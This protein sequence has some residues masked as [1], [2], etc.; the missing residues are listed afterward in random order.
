MVTD[1][2]YRLAQWEGEMTPKQI[3]LARHAL[4]LPNKARRSY[5]N[6]FCASPGH[7]DYDDWML[8]VESAMARKFR[9]NQITGGDDVFSL[10][11]AGARKAL[12]R[13]EHLDPADFP[14]GH[15]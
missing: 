14:A 2:G 8:M 6:H 9:G 15:P 7:D 3:E 11:V 1:G 12:K 4:G 10:T 5:R 13:G